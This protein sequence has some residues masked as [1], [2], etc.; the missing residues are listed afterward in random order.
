V[1]TVFYEFENF[2]MN[3]YD[4]YKWFF[5]RFSYSIIHNMFRVMQVSWLCM[6]L[7]MCALIAYEF[8]FCGVD[9]GFKLCRSHDL[10]CETCCFVVGISYHFMY[11]LVCNGMR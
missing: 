9:L 2:A 10:K 4:D 6:K 8:I 11:I 5:V 7:F 1:L 3:I